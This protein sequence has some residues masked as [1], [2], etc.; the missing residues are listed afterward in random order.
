M[1]VIGVFRIGLNDDDDG[2]VVMASS[3]S[4]LLAGHGEGH[5][6][7]E[8]ILVKNTNRIQLT[9]LLVF[10]EEKPRVNVQKTDARWWHK[11]PKSVWLLSIYIV[12]IAFLASWRKKT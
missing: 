5:I 3:T 7:S 8:Y 6:P 2:E 11:V 1:S 10:G 9:H 12:F 4:S